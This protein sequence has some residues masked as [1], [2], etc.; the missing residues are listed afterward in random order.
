MRPATRLFAS[1]KSGARYLEA[2]TPTGL[3]GLYTH[4]APRSTLIYLYSKTLEKLKQ[5][6]ES[7]VYRQSSEAV[8]KH[9]MEIISSVKPAGYDE[10][11]A[12]AKKL[13]EEH[14]EVF[15]TPEGG[16]DYDKGRH[17]KEVLGGRSFVTTKAEED[18]DETRLEWDGEPD[19]GPELE[20]VRTAEEKKS[21]SVLSKRRPGE[22][23]KQIKWEPEPALTAE[24]IQEVENKIGAGLIEEVIQ[25]AEGELKLVD[26]MLQAKPWEDLEE[27]PVEGQWTYFDGRDGSPAS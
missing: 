1:V 9:R 12:K 20:G 23:E 13:L 10:W 14:P 8:A 3:A 4:P 24:Q 7:S 18:L 11:A 21:L 26:V 25:V 5:I 6:P 15:N 22:D 16:V 17:L 19:L 27:K 2:N